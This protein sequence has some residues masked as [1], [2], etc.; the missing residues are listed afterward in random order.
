LLDELFGGL[1]AAND[2]IERVCPMCGSAVAG[3]KSKKFCCAKCRRANE[4]LNRDLDAERIRR[5]ELAPERVCEH[6]GATF[7]R[8]S[9]SKNAAR[10]CSRRCGFDAGSNI[11]ESQRLRSAAASM[12]VSF[13]VKVCR[14]AACGSRFRA[15]NLAEKYCG[16]DCRNE[17]TRERYIAANDNGRDRSERPCAECGTYFAPEYGDRRRMFCSSECSAKKARRVSHRKNRARLR[18]AFVENVDPISVFERDGWTCRDCGLATPREKRGTYDAD[19]PELDHIMPLSLG[20]AHS[21]MNTQCL[22][23]SCNAKKG[24]TPPQQVSL[25]AYG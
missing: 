9:D 13:I 14:C 17:F 23:R 15:T 6:C 19:A 20:G 21:Y 3:P 2:N 11:S 8:R 1:V 25:F 4:R 5:E 7:R 22:C 16:Q 12:N 24:N 18:N 10:F